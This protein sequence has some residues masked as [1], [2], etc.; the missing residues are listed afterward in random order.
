MFSSKATKALQRI[1][2]ETNATVV[3]TTSHKS[4]FSIAEWIAIF[5]RRGIELNALERLP[6]NTA[7]LNRREEILNWLNEQDALETFINFRR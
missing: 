6:E 7:F 3:L 5:Q 2:K 1:L 4:T